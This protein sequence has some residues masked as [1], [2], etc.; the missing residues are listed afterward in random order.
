MVLIDE[1]LSLFYQQVMNTHF[2]KEKRG[3]MNKP[4][5]LLKKKKNR[6][7]LSSSSSGVERYENLAIIPQFKVCLSSGRCGEMVDAVDSKSTLGN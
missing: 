3:F 2:I 7:N 6:D 5:T 4:T 1:G